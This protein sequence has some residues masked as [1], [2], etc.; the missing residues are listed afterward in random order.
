MSRCRSCGGPVAD[1][2]V[3][4]AECR[5]KLWGNPPAPPDPAE[6]RRQDR[7]AGMAVEAAAWLLLA[8]GIAF[9]WGILRML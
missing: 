2:L 6:Q 8:A 1:G 9:F 4:C 7:L 3:R 5:I